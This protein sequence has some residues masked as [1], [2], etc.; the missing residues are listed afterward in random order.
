MSFV[1]AYLDDDSNVVVSVSADFAKSAGLKTL[2]EPALGRNGLPLRPR[3]GNRT[4]AKKAA[5]TPTGGQ[6]ASKPEEGSA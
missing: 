2:K 1:S 3:E 6:S 4:S 5:N